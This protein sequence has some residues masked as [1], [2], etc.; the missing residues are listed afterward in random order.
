MTL[1]V[2]GLD[3]DAGAHEGA[4]PDARLLLMVDVSDCFA[5]E[6]DDAA[7]RTHFLM[8]VAR[9]SLCGRVVEMTP[10]PQAVQR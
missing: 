5:F 3:L 8:T 2:L 4:A 9:R 7:R 1:T 6:C 10:R